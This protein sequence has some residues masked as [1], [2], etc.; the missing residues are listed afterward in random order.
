MQDNT[1]LF[2]I[3]DMSGLQKFG[4]TDFYLQYDEKAER[5]NILD[6]TYDAY[7]TVLSYPKRPV[8]EIQELFDAYYA[9]YRYGVILGETEGWLHLQHEMRALLNI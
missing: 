3:E 9:G 6:A 8:E 1:R 4:D 5:Y 7:N 2:E